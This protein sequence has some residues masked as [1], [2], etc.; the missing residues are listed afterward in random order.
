MLVV[1]KVASLLVMHLKRPSFDH[2]LS[3]RN[4]PHHHLIHLCLLSAHLVS[5][6]AFKPFGEVEA[7]RGKVRGSTNLTVCLKRAQRCL[8]LW[9]QRIK[10]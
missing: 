4:Q 10:A 2:H 6:E 3:C 9:L 8:P 7:L 1:L 5:D